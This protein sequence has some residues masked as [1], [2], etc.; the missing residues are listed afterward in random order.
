MNQELNATLKSHDLAL[1][2]RAVARHLS[3]AGHADPVEIAREAGFTLT[4][5]V[6]SLNHLA[7]LGIAR[8]QS[9]Y[10]ATHGQYMWC[11]TRVEWLA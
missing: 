4:S 11:L 5:V 1:E 9:V 3:R 2:T 10:N 6:F 8:E 7:E